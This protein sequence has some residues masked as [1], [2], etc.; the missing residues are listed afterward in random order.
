MAGAIDPDD[1]GKDDSGFFLLHFPFAYEYWQEVTK[2]MQAH[3]FG[4][5]RP[6]A[7]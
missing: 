1:L 5:L 3:D 7:Q 6:S 4:R 2:T